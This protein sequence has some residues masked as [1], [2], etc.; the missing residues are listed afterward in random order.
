M[1]VRWRIW[2]TN[3]LATARRRTQYQHDFDFVVRRR[4]GD[5]RTFEHCPRYL[6]RYEIAPNGRAQRGHWFLSSPGFAFW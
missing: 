2:R 4:V 3:R 1:A 6:P 5:G